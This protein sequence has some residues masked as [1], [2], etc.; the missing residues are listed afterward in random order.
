MLRLGFKYMLIK[1]Y[2]ELL[3]PPYQDYIV[4]FQNRE[5]YLYKEQVL[6]VGEMKHEHEINI[7]TTFLNI[8]QRRIKLVEKLPTVVELKK[9]LSWMHS[10]QYLGLDIQEEAWAQKVGL[11]SLKKF[12]QIHINKPLVKELICSFNYDNQY[13]KVGE[14]IYQHR[15]GRHSEGVQ[16]TLQR[17][18]G[19][20]M[21]R[22]QWCYCQWCL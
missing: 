17:I 22:V 21:K 19:K 6:N 9:V 10:W 8:K 12:N 11:V 14:M 3:E 1:V 13:V 4:V 20:S 5:F 15:Q 2:K 16:T 18:D 7:G